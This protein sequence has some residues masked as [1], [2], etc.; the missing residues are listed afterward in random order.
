MIGTAITNN[1]M[2]CHSILFASFQALS[3]ADVMFDSGQSSRTPSCFAGSYAGNLSASSPSQG[4][5][6]ATQVQI[7]YEGHREHDHGYDYRQRYDVLPF[8]FIFSF[9]IPISSSLPGSRFF[10]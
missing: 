3:E 4:S 10:P 5:K 8:H 2:N 1:M 9:S 7:P 6:H